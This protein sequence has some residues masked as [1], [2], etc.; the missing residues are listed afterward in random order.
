MCWKGRIPA[1]RGMAL[2]VTI[3]VV[4]LIAILAVA[5]LSLAGRLLQE[6]TLAIRDAR[7][8]ASVAY[9][10]AS[11]SDEWRSRSIGRLAVGASVVFTPSLGGI[12]VAL[13]VSVTRIGADVFW[14]ASE[15]AA[16]GGAVRRENLIVRRRLPDAQALIADDSTNVGSLG[17]MSVDSIA[18]SADTQL[19]AGAT[20]DSPA[21]VTHVAGNAALFGVGSGILIVD[22]TLAIVGPLAFQGVVI[23]KGGISVAAPM[24]SMKGLVRSPLIDGNIGS[25]RDAAVV[26]DVMGQLVMPLPVR[27]R[28]WQELH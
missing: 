24:V 8:D 28:R 17:F 16:D 15:A 6:S 7:L 4:S 26:Q 19:P 18:A 23:A 13:T 14:I 5:T 22:G 27:G 25:I 9:G 20:L 3:G 12:P 11:A 2:A 10:L 1:R 21:G